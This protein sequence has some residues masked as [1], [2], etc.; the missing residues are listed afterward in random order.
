MRDDEKPERVTGADRESCCRH[1]SENSA[2]A[3][4][5]ET[6]VGDVVLELLSTKSESED[7][8]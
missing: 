7:A 1:E 6:C 4:P 2:G 3:E 8:W 5:T